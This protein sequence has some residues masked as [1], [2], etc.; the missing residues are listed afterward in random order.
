MCW[1]KRSDEYDSVYK[2]GTVKG[3]SVARTRSKPRYINITFRV[4]WQ[5]PKNIKRYDVDE[6]RKMFPFQRTEKE[7]TCWNFLGK[8]EDIH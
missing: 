7:K 5:L 6:S 3:E 4:R 2:K 1:N 8:K